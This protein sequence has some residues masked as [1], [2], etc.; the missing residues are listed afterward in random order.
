MKKTINW[1]ET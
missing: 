1:T